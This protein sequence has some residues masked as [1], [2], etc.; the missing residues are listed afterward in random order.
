MNIA[1]CDDNALSRKLLNNLL[2][3][4]FSKKSINHKIDQYSNGMDLLYEFE[5]GRSYEIIFL[6]ILMEKILGIEVAKRLRKLGYNGEIIFLSASSDFAV[7]SYDV[8]AS[9]YIL[10][11]INYENLSLSIDR[12]IRNIGIGTY[13]IQRR[14]NFIIV[15]YDE[16]IYIES[17]NSKCILHRNNGENYN[18]YKKLSQ[19]EKEL[20]DQRFLRSHQSYLVNMDYIVG[21]SNQFQLSTGES[22]L[23]R[24]RNL[25]DI[26]SAYL[27]YAKKRHRLY[28][29]VIEK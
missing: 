3:N 7:E 5:D 19:I 27:E 25:K 17:S 26:R 10:K 12:T 15:P 1:I 18:I 20:N 21:V 9:G 14:N 23:I 4:Y 28:T 29:H 6:D 16:I 2:E 13:H 24:Q 8:K 22:V 11:P